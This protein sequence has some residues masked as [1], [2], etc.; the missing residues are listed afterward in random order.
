MVPTLQLTVSD[1]TIVSQ[2][3]IRKLL[4]R[5]FPIISVSQKIFSIFFLTME[6]IG[7]G[8]K[9]FCYHNISN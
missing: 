7:I 5:L 8:E 3:R 6:K 4:F 2:V 9:V 1:Y